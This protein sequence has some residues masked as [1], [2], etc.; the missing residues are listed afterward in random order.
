[1]RIKTLLV[2]GALLALGACSTKIKKDYTTVDFSH[3]KRPEW[4]REGVYKPK[5]KENEYKFFISEADNVN[6]R[7]CEK[8]AEARGASVLSS[9]IANRIENSYQEVAESKNLQKEAF[10][11]EKLKQ[12]IQSYL[13][14]LE[15]ES[16]YWEKRNYQRSLG[17][18][19]D[20]AKYKCFSLLKIKKSVYDRAV[21]LSLNKIFKEIGA[22]DSETKNEVKEK[23]LDIEQ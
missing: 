9:E 20:V 3:E 16:S 8:S 5:E 17:A 11:S 15:K 19:E 12:T 1:M 14:G 6:R 21:E 18:E 7:L 23:V 13:A 22:T 2:G 4:V 10:S